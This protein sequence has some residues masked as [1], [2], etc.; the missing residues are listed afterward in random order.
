MNCNVAPAGCEYAALVAP[1]LIAALV[2]GYTAR[3]LAL[4]FVIEITIPATAVGSLTPA[5]EAT[6][7]TTFISFVIAVA[8]PCTVPAAVIAVPTER[9]T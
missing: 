3:L 6:V 7:E 1:V 4:V 9:I 2:A 5:P 8:L